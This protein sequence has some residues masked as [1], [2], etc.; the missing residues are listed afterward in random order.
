MI[1]CEGKVD[2]GWGAEGKPLLP[3]CATILSAPIAVILLGFQINV[4]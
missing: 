1:I 3:L 4:I 2:K